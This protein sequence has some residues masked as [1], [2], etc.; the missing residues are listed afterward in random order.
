MSTMP[1]NK[2]TAL[3]II[4]IINKSIIFL[5]S[6]YFVIFNSSASIA[7]GKSKIQIKNI[8]G[9]PLVCIC[10]MLVYL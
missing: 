3:N 9:P 8:E 4:I 10:D 2:H 5:S 1:K 7:S 6:V